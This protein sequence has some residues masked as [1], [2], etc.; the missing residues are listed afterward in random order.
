MAQEE[1]LENNKLIA[2]FMKFPINTKH[3]MYDTRTYYDISLLQLP[4]FIKVACLEQYDFHRDWNWLMPVIK[5]TRDKILNP[6]LHIQLN[7]A[8]LELDIKKVYKTVVGLI[9]Y[10]SKN[11]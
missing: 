8:L 10:N 9:K 11:L 5:E 1:I 6:R 3:V 4:S 2:E 7:D